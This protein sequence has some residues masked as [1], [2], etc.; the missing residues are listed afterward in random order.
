[1]TIS[2]ARVA[3]NIPGAL[4]RRLCKHW[5]HKFPVSYDEHHGDVQLSRGRCV[6]QVVGDAV[7]VRLHAESD[8]D[9][10]HLERVV[11]EHLHRMAGKETLTFDWQRLH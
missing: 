5:G 7:Q 1:M 11:G 4:I 10:E 6:M 9:L 3:T 8:K 2:S